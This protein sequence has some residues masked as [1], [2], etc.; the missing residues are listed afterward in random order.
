MKFSAWPGLTGPYDRLIEL[1]QH[2]ER[3]GWDGI[4]IADH[5]MPNQEDNSGP[6]G[7]IWTN[8][9]AIA[10]NVPRVRIGT[11]V[12]GNT[13]RH[14][15]VV[16]KMA[17]QVDIISG[18][19]LVLG[20]GAGWQENEHEAY[21]IPYHTVGGRLRRLEESVQIIRGL[22]REERT[23][24]EGRFYT[25]KDAPLAPK[26]V[27]PV[28]ILI[29]GGGEQ[30][31]L[32]ITAQYADEWNTWGSPNTLARKGAVLEQ[33]CEDIGR[34]P[35]EI[36]RSAQALLTISNDPAEVERARG[37]GRPTLAGSVD[38][39]VD[40]LGKYQEAKVDEFI[41]PQAGLGDRAQEVFD[42]FIEDI[43]PQLR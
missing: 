18:G 25:V 15:P 39:I 12:V 43:A 3:T 14:P 5:F 2:V 17:A 11:L 28:P 16:A 27:G 21:G 31:T 38:E 8:L 26:P 29:G 40:T 22:L 9:A 42:Q 10:V 36:R 6:T 30:V 41:V 24:F 34:N 35:A 37:I 23:T 19:R 4:W 7:E 20:M 32:R 1:C 33:H 13:Y